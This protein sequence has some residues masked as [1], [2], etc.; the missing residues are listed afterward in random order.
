MDVNVDVLDE[1]DDSVVVDQGRGCET[2]DY[3]TDSSKD[4]I[5]FSSSDS[6]NDGD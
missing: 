5:S 4:D 6:G 2:T 3:G 1:Q